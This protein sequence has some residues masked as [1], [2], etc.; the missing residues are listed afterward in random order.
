MITIDDIL[1]LARTIYG[2][3]RGEHD[4]AQRAVAHVVINRWRSPRFRAGHSISA[5]C[6]RYKQFSAW[7]R[8][9]ATRR[10]DVNREK[11]QAATVDDLTFRRCFLSALAAIDEPDFTYGAMHYHTR[12]VQP[13][14]SEGHRP[15]YMAARHL[16]FNDID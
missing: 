7:N 10:N 16:F 2:E 3:A 8:N 15:C 9:K 13:G 11:M 6:L 1:I 12:D 4:T 14:W 5:V